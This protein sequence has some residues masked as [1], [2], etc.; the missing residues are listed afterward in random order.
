M[1]DVGRG[2]CLVVV[3][4]PLTRGTVV[5][6][7][8][9]C[10][11]LA[12]PIVAT[13]RVAW[14]RS[15]V[16]GIEFTVDAAARAGVQLHQLVSDQPHLRPTQTFPRQL[17]P[18]TYLQP[19]SPRPATGLSADE[20]LMAQ[21]VGDGIRARILM[22]RSGLPRDRARRAIFGLLEKGIVAV[23]VRESAAEPEAT[24]NALSPP[25]PRSA[26]RQLR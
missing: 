7:S 8:L 23:P 15:C 26:A 25:E 21:H 17:E 16:T 20:S 5:N 22:T 14:S 2:G 6:V 11:G 1:K 24:A 10:D 9:S 18:A 3:D 13:G 12:E 4:E 19:R